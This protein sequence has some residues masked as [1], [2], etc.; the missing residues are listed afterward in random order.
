MQKRK[1]NVS[2]NIKKLGSNKLKKKT[3]TRYPNNE[4]FSTKNK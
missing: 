3:F 2:L 1:K 4:L